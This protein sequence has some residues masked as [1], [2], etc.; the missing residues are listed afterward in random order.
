MQENLWSF[1]KNPCG[2]A[3]VV[4]S[5]FN[6]ISGIDQQLNWEEVFTEEVSL[7]LHKHL[8]HS[9]RSNMS[10]SK[11]SGY[12]LPGRNLVKIW[13]NIDCLF[14]THFQER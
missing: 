5:A 2:K 14:K 13:Y 7:Q 8:H 4:E 6:K 3:S 9:Q 11:I 12:L 10:S 1:E